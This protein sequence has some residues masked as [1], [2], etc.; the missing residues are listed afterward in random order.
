MV[1]MPLWLKQDLGLSNDLLRWTDGAC[2]VPLFPVA[3]NNDHRFG[4]HFLGTCP[5]MNRWKGACEMAIP[6]SSIKRRGKVYYL[7]F[8][9]GGV[10][11]RVSLHTDSLPVARELQ[12]QFDSARAHGARNMFPTKTPLGEAVGAYVA[13]MKVCRTRHGYTA[14]ISYL[15][16]AFGPICVALKPRRRHCRPVEVE[17]DRRRRESVIAAACLEDIT[18]AQVSDFIRGR[19]EKLGLQPKTANRYREVLRRLFSWSMEERGVRMP[20]GG[21][22]VTKVKRYKENAPEI[23]FLNIEEI[24]HQ[25]EVLRGNPVLHA[26]VA[27]YIYAGLRR[28]EAIWLTLEDVDLAAGTPGVIRVRAK[29]VDG[30]Y[31][32]PKTKTNRVV[33]V[34]RA[35]R[36]VLDGYSRSRAISPWYFPSPKGKRWD[37]DNFSQTLR[38]INRAAGLP[39]S[40]LDYR[41]TFGSNLAMKGA[42]LYKISALMGN[43]PEICRRH[44]AALLPESLIA[45][46]EFMDEG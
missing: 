14:D 12:R 25:L 33:P 21:N 30:E 15:R 27:T 42:S 29:T 19:V 37:P 44:Y 13:H 11:R 16:N 26:M 24:V 7:R 9:E 43:S 3:R 45:S 46:V 39:W 2:S 31:W 4:I 1:I 28:E 20:A 35:L 40:C 36:Q 10:R 32:E 22:P 17:D 6:K 41:H 5:T 34:S 18:V 23:R 8:S 38:V